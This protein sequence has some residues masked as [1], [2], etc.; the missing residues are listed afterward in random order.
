MQNPSAILEMYMVK[1]LKNG[2]LLSLSS[3]RKIRLR[4]FC[5]FSVAKQPPMGTSLDY[6]RCFERIGKMA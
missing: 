3:K 5:A 6:S 2:F 1:M 4:F